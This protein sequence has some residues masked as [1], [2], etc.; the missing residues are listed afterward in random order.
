MGA[1]PE[2]QGRIGVAEL[3]PAGGVALSNKPLKL[4]A[5][6]LGGQA[7][8]HGRGPPGRR[9]TRERPPVDIR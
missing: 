8:P 1:R 7:A 3:A 5:A 2:R 4:T 6:G 9:L